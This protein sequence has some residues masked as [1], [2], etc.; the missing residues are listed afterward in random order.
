MT[1]GV[2]NV[3]GASL[4]ARL[5]KNGASLLLLCG[6]QVLFSSEQRGIAPLLEAVERMNDKDLSGAT[7]VDRVIG[8]AGALLALHL[9][10]SF[11]AAGVISRSGAE[12]F[13]R[14]DVPFYAQETV[15]RI[16]GRGAGP[17]PFESSVQAVDAPEDALRI[18][19][20]VAKRLR[21]G[22]PPTA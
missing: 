19:Q 2:Y 22:G 17:C 9:G 4:L 1:D 11:V 14:H 16:E 3:R 20:D 13:T 15:V 21:S 6:E 5:G 7:L 12:V 18:L 10:V 8:K